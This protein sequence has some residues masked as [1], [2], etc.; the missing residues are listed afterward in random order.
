MPPSFCMA[1]VWHVGDEIIIFRALQLSLGFLLL[2]TVVGVGFPVGKSLRFLLDPGCPTCINTG[3]LF[4]LSY[5]ANLTSL[6]SSLRKILENFV[7]LFEERSCRA[8]QKLKPDEFGDRDMLSKVVRARSSSLVERQRD[9]D[10]PFR[11][12]SLKHGVDL[13]SQIPLEVRL[14]EARKARESSARTKGSSATSATDPK[15]DKS[16]PA[17]DAGVSDLLKTQFL[18]SPSSCAELVDQI[19]QAGD[20]GTFSSLSL[21]KQKEATLHLLQKGIVFA[22][23]TI[24]NSSAVTPIFCSAQRVG[25]EECRVS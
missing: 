2:L 20:L 4:T 22:A 6:L 23:E 11:N 14:A 21:E 1:L 25:E 16:S 24:R 10:A 19:R 17:G 3:L 9:A 7:L 8:S 15:V 13:T 12:S 5:I 18:S